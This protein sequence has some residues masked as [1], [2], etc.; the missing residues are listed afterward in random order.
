MFLSEKL[1]STPFLGCVQVSQSHKQAS[2]HTLFVKQI[3][4][5]GR[6]PSPSLNPTRN[7]LLNLESQ[8]RIP[9]SSFEGLVR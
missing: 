6:Y 2:C 7:N 4:T 1:P 5:Y 3:V 9:A 8:H